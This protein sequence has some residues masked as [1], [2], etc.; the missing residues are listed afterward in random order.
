MNN[1]ITPTGT[2]N[3]YPKIFDLDTLKAEAQSLGITPTRPNIRRIRRAFD[4]IEK[5]HITHTANLEG[6]RL[7]EVKSQ[8]RN[9]HVHLVVSNE[10]T[11]CTCEDARRLRREGQTGCKHAIAVRLQEAQTPENAQANKERVV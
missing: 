4:L 9:S 10:I 5:G 6:A 2:S 8:T 3:D 1:N 11:Q 7:Y